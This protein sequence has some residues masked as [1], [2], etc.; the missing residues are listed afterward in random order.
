MPNSLYMNYTATG[1]G[2]PKEN[3]V[4]VRVLWASLNPL[5]YKLAEFPIAGKYIS[6]TPCSPGLDFSGIVTEIGKGVTHLKVDERCYGKLPTLP[7][8]TGSC[9]KMI[10]VQA[11]NVVKCPESVELRDAAC[12]GTAALAAFQ[13]IVPYATRRSNVFINGGSG[14]CGVFCVQLA[15]IF[16]CRVTATC[17]TEKIAFVRGLGADDVVDYKLVDVVEGL[18]TKERKY[19]LVIDNV[20]STPDLYAKCRHFAT[21]NARFIQIGADVSIPHGFKIV[22]RKLVPRFLG[23]GRRRYQYLQV[24]DNRAHMETLGEWLAQGLIQVPIDE[25]FHFGNVPRA[26]HKLKEGHAQGKIVIDMDR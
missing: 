10:S 15:K 4:T 3:F 25:A 7:G 23:R 16:G 21:P 24:K 18:L 22:H 8:R 6:G 12:L 13:A 5:D 19:D 20:G 17:S 1:P 11:K 14:G 2:P 9:S 26:F